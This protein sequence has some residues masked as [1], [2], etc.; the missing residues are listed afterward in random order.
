MGSYNRYVAAEESKALTRSISQAI[1]VHHPENS[2]LFG[3]L[4]VLTS[5]NM[6]RIDGFSVKSNDTNY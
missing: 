3:N 5:V 1:V 4:H 6:C 2:A